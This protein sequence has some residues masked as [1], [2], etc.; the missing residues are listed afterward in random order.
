MAKELSAFWKSQSKNQI[1]LF[2]PEQVLS[3]KSQ[4]Y[5]SLT[6]ALQLC[7]VLFLYGFASVLALGEIKSYLQGEQTEVV[8]TL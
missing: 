8:Q 1:L 6:T 5:G 7:Q 4:A 2:P 3:V